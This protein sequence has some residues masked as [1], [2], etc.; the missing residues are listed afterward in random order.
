[1]RNN[2]HW[3]LVGLYCSKQISKNYSVGKLLF[4]IYIKKSII[5]GRIHWKDAVQLNSQLQLQA[6]SISWR[7][8]H[9][10]TWKFFFH[11]FFVIEVDRPARKPSL[12]STEVLVPQALTTVFLDFITMFISPPTFTYLQN[13][14]KKYKFS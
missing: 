11:V 10:F 8:E 12:V 7:Q 9:F 5:K 4:F 1:M 14:T 2:K 3:G 13:L 6:R